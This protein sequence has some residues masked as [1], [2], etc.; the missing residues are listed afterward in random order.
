VTGKL[1]LCEFENVSEVVK[2]EVQRITIAIEGSKPAL[3]HIAQGHC[4]VGYSIDDLFNHNYSGLH[5]D[6]E[7]Y[8][9]LRPLKG[10]H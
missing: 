1:G 3:L 9:K 8:L 6:F 10:V 5:H 4:T 2:R 7:D